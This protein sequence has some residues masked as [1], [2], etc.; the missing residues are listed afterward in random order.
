MLSNAHGVRLPAIRA[1]VRSRLCVF[2]CLLPV[3]SNCATRSLSLDPAGGPSDPAAPVPELVYRSV[4]AGTTDY[5]PVGPAPWRDV[6]DRVAPGGRR[7][8]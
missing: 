6:N 4:S 3:L 2:A 1:A 5:Q 8:P 7:A